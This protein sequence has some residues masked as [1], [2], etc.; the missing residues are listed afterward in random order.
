MSLKNTALKTAGGA[1]STG[2]KTGMDLLL[3]VKLLF[4]LVILLQ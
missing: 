3:F 2:G 1:T 4:S